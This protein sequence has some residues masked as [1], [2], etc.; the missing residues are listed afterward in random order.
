MAENKIAEPTSLKSIATTA[1]GN[2]TDQVYGI[3]SGR[4][5]AKYTGGARCVLKINDELVG[6]AFQ[7]AWEINTDVKEIFTVDEYTPADMAPTLCTVRGSLG[8]F[9]IPGNGP[10]TKQWQA[11][12]KSFLVHKYI[13][14]EV[15]DSQTDELLFYTNKAVITNRSQSMQAGSLSKMNLQW[16]AIGWLDEKNQKVQ[17]IDPGTEEGSTDVFAELGNRVRNLIG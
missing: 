1:V 12:L 5:I 9:H 7:V 11:T 15:R 2:A 10:G 8:A 17:G 16:K 6:F 3:V 13:A 14:I 4:Q